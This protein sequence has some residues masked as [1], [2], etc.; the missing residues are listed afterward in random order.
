MYDAAY[1]ISGRRLLAWKTINLP[2]IPPLGYTLW[3]NENICGVIE[4]GDI[5]EDGE[6]DLKISTDMEEE[7]DAMNDEIV[8]HIIREEI[9][10]LKED[11]CRYK[12]YLRGSNKYSYDL[13][14]EWNPCDEDGPQ[15]VGME[16]N[17]DS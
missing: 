11:G 14:E 4:S 12:Y 5:H 17:G 7:D 8:A 1:P 3:I 15:R 10:H 2:Y 16:D 13:Q 6:V 9:E